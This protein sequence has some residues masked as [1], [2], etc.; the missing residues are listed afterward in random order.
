MNKNEDLIIEIFSGT[1]WESEMISGLLLNSGIKSFLKNNVLNSYAIEPTF[2]G[3]VK[4]MILE[5][6]FE[7][8]KEI[9]DE[10]Y[11]NMKI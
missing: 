3:G 7:R 5:S 1:P 4:V 10:Y 9:V 11:R 6:D 2:P 8:A